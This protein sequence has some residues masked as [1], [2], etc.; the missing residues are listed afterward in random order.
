M[1]DRLKS[2]TLKQKLVAGGGIGALLLM[3]AVF[4][5]LVTA[6]DFAPLYAGLPEESLAAIADELD[7]EG[8]E[9]RLKGRTIEVPQSVLQRTKL[10]LAA[11][12]MPATGPAGYELLDELDGFSTTSEMFSVAYWRA[13]EGELARTILA[14]PGVEAARV[15]IASGTEGRFAA[16]R[17]DRTASV[18]ISAPGGLSG[19][20]IRAVRHLTSLAVPGL[21]PDAVAVVDAQRGLLS[22]EQDGFGQGPGNPGEE[23]LAARITEL[24][25]ARVG[26][27]NARVSVAAHI[28][29]RH[30]ELEEFTP[31]GALAVPTRTVRE[32][33]TERNN[34]SARP[35][36]VASDLP[37]PD[38]EEDQNSSNRSETRDE[39]QL[40]VGHR[41]R[42]VEIP[43]GTIERL[44][45]AVLINNPAG[46]DGEPVERSAEELASLEALVRAAAGVDDARGDQVIVRSMTFEAP[47]A[48][49]L[50]TQADDASSNRARTWQIAAG[51]VLLL[52]LSAGGLAL[53][54]RRKP[55]GQD[56][57]DPTLAGEAPL[58][59]SAAGATGTE[60]DSLGRAKLLSREKPQAAALL[61][62]HWLQEGETQ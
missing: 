32:E 58:T 30:E 23:K 16:R 12:G 28:S 61:L 39:A 56:L 5:R 8:V 51:G 52:I 11:K 40:V 7:K 47:L 1:V 4:M 9:Y 24:L 42:R 19:G 55:K 22:A 17:T 15:H 50:A 38:A 35:V 34:A 60:N 53:T 29:Q 43:A 36:T 46:P 26:F 48:P 62:E 59:I 37:D 44:S 31:D 2:L 49:F 3:L 57:A 33:I 18:F 45:V 6:P 54:M 21:A 20:Q 13:K 14:I 27:G 10:A 25:E 41:S